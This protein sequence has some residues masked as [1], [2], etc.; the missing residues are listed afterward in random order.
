MN[1]ID[2]A[3][4]RD[5]EVIIRLSLSLLDEDNIIS[6]YLYGGYGRDEGSWVIEEINGRKQAKPYNDYDIALIV[7]KKLPKE[8]LFIL[9]SELKKYVD[10]KWIDISQYTLS[11]LKHFKARIQNYDFKYASKWIYGRRDILDNIPEMDAKGITLK[12][13]EILY[14]TR[15]WTLIGS[16]PKEGLQK[17]SKENEMFFRNQMAKCVLAVVDCILVSEQEYDPSYRKRVAKILEITTDEDLKHLSKWAL[18]EKLFPSYTGMAENQILDLYLTIN[19][20]F[21]RNFF[22]VL[23]EYYGAEIRKPEDAYKRIR[24]GRSN[25]IKEKV[26]KFLFNDNRQELNMHLVDLQGQIAYYY[27]DMAPSRL[28]KIQL[29]MENIFAFSSNDI[30]EIRLKIAELRAG[31]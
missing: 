25:F 7:K 31:L 14:V 30:E 21:F 24:Y 10:V 6:I 11:K 28:E 23:S 3:L 27:F 1:E 15:I 22:S 18:E 17:M 29:K 16:F 19:R 9:E 8:R 26:K 4:N 2:K 20:L 13:V 12:D 5:I